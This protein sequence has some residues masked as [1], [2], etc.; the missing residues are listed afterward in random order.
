MDVKTVNGA[1]R[2]LVWLL[3]PTAPV[4]EVSSEQ[5]EQRVKSTIRVENQAA[6]IRAE[7]LAELRRR[8]G[9]GLVETVLREGGLMPR[10]R[11]RSEVETASDLSGLPNTSEGL[12]NGEIPYH[13]ARIIAGA[14]RRGDIDE[15]ELAEIAKTQSPDKF[16][17]T[18][19]KHEQQRSEDDGVSR[20]KHQRSRRFARIKTDPDDGMTILYGRFD[21]VA[22]ARIET[23]LSKKMDDLWREDPRKRTR[24][25]QRMADAL[26]LLMTRP[27]GEGD[28][29]QDVKL[30]ITAEYDVIA[31]RLGNA[32]LPDG[33][34]L[35]ADE[36]RKLAC[37]AQILPAIFSGAS[38]PLD[39]GRTRR[40]ASGSQR[41]AL[42]RRDRSC[43]GCGASASWC[44][45]HHIVFWRDGGRTD[46]NNLVLLCS[47]C[48]HKVHD[49]GWRVERARGGAFGLRRP[50][51]GHGRSPRPGYNRERHRRRRRK[52][53]RQATKQQK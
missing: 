21:P 25:G 34:P 12:R 43:V 1:D 35:P 17:G 5:L 52:R 16:A 38:Q 47:R 20:L 37:D 10:R 4:A 11:A 31:Q 13:N 39:L 50:P 3:A 8:E 51:T 28:R 24:P 30:L 48:H 9:A 15:G 44:Q 7:A 14:S 41:A 32:H 27:G 6:A 49:D 36:L 19:R 45:A 23:A 26:E 29:G 18:V 53:R 33:T 40:L 2:N 46:I 42:V 22:G